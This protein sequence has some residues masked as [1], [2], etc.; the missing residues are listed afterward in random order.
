MVL[1]FHPA[2]QQAATETTLLSSVEPMD[3]RARTFFGYP[4]EQLTPK[5]DLD[6]FRYL[7]PLLKD[8]LKTGV[9]RGVRSYGDKVFIIMGATRNVDFEELSNYMT[10]RQ[11]ATMGG[12]YII[13]GYVENPKA[14]QEVYF[15][16]DVG[17]VMADAELE[18]EYKEMPTGPVTDQFYV[19]DLLRADLVNNVTGECVF[20]YPINGTGITIGLAD[21]G[22]DFGVP[23]LSTA[24]ATDPSLGGPSSFD[25]GG[26]GIAIT[27]FFGVPVGGYLYTEG[28]DFPMWLGDSGVMVYSNSTYGFYTEN[29][30]VGDP[31]HGVPR[32]GWIAVGMAVQVASGLPRARQ[33]FLFL[34]T[35]NGSTPT[36]LIDWDTSWALTAEYNGLDSLGKTAEWDFTDDID[37]PHVWGAGT[38]VLATD[39]DGDG[40]ADFSMGSLACTLDLFGILSGDLVVG[41]DPNLGGFAYMYDYD[42]HGTSTAAAAA[43]RGE[44]GYDVY[45]NGTLYKLPGIAPGAKVMALKLFTFGDYMWTWLW[46]SGYH[47]NTADPTVSPYHLYT[48]WTYTGDHQCQLISNSWGFI[49]FM[50]FGEPYN[51]VWGFDWTSW[52]VDYL[53]AW[54]GTLFVISS[55]NNGPGYGTGGAPMS[56]SAL[57]VGASTS[58]H[59]WQ[60]LYDNNSN[61][62]P[63]ADQIVSFSSNGPMPIGVP[64]PNLVAVGL[65]SFV[66]DAL[67]YGMGDG[68]TA[69]GIFAG[70]SLAAP[71]AAGV[72]ALV[73]QAGY[74]KGTLV[75]LGT[76][77]P[78]PGVAKSILESTAKDLGYDAFRQGAGR[79]DAFRAVHA[80][81]GNSTDGTDPILVAQ[82]P[83]TFDKVAALGDRSSGWRGFYMGLFLGDLVYGNGFPAWF[84]GANYTVATYLWYHYFHPSAFGFSVMDDSIYTGSMFPGDSQI[85]QMT[86]GDLGGVGTA[87]SAAAYELV[88]LNESS[89]ILHSTSTYTTW[90]LADH[91]DTSFMQQWNSCDYAVIHLTYPVDEFESLFDLTAMSNYVFLHDWNDTNG[92]GVI[93]LTSA[94]ASGEVR[95]ISADTSY[96][97]CHQI[98][99][100]KPG[101]AF[102]KMGKGSKGPTIYYH[103]VGNE[104]YLWRTLDV[105][106]TIRL[107]HKVPWQGTPIDVDVTHDTGTTWNVTVT[108]DGSATP[109]IF[110]GIIEWTKGG[111]VAAI[112]PMTVR[113]DGLCP[114]D[115]TLS[116]GGSDGRP[117]DN[118]ATFG[119]IDWGGGGTTGDW[120]FYYVDVSYYYNN[121]T[122]DFTTWIMTNVSWTNP[123]TIID[124]YVYMTG[125]GN[126][127]YFGPYSATQSETEYVGGGRWDSTPT[128]TAQNVLLTDFTWEVS[129]SWD[130]NYT[131]PGAWYH[132]KSTGSCAHRGYLGIA[133]HT[134]RYGS[135][136]APENFTITV[137]PIRNSTMTSYRE[138][139]VDYPQW[140]EWDS[141][142]LEW[143]PNGTY[144]P[145]FDINITHNALDGL[146]SNR[147]YAIINATSHANAPVHSDSVWV[148][149]HVKF[150]ASWSDLSLPGFPSVK[151]RQTQIELLSG[152]E[153]EHYG[154]ITEGFVPGWHPDLNPREAYDYVWLLAGQEVYIEVEFGT[155]SAGE[156]STLIHGPNDDCDIFVWAPGAAHTGANSLVGYT[157]STTANP[158]TGTFVAPVTGNYTIGID[159]YSGVQ[160]MGWR[161]YVKA[162]QATTVT[163]DGR[164]AEMDTQITGTNAT[165]DVRTRFITGTSLDSVSAFNSYT[166]TNVTITNF[167]VPTVQV[168]Y[169][170]G[171][172]VVGPD[173]FTI[174]WTASDPNEPEEIL[175]FSVEISNDS[176]QT[177]KVIVYGTTQKQATWDPGST[178]YLQVNTS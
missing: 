91:F 151:I 17:V 92:N 172:E 64:K 142:W 24:Y 12:G 167:F 23:D 159:Y 128:W 156:G 41:I 102:Y 43:G 90:P 10:I 144:A 20:D 77:S 146:M 178:V 174:T 121:A 135:M 148:G 13:H 107:Y 162:S 104:V 32:S 82:S 15:M 140:A 99:V 147:P 111:K 39:L 63:G 114:P 7:D 134:V 28:F 109:G 71:L 176:G 133:I 84:D 8:Y 136:S 150:N 116:W 155:W 164:W 139:Y 78:D 76:G 175:G 95:R 38:E 115:L 120:R 98:H 85:L 34:L 27:S 69:V 157:M 29:I 88:L 81:F 170:N 33:F 118:G 158:E 79:V 72:A 2:I 51:F 113:V 37:D 165:Y 141:Y 16:P 126:N 53:T 57:S 96:S 166:V 42:G 93:D 14:L 21:T 123:D 44:V 177:W 169:P 86:V 68:S 47:P 1:V 108:V 66:V 59:I 70:T 89:A 153:Q 50:P 80:A 100:G 49:Y 30:Y 45:G 125:Y 26:T 52:L 122:D 40:I 97:N 6:P 73:Y 94:D 160:P 171:G 131:T 62:E 25:P 149:P 112:T 110:E 19:Q 168:I 75:G 5:P 101:D 154:T 145:G 3:S 55:G 74:D 83:S 54:T 9:A 152:I 58:T 161:C 87:D 124:V 117:Y 31:V 143:A 11:V 106:V 132:T 138:A 56:A 105:N 18:F 163:S 129:G 61:W 48:N 65:G 36:L 46:G 67:H 103:D 130:W 60:P 119:G 22:T 127:A 173:P 137:T 35:M 4:S